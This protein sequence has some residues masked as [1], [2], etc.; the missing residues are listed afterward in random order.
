VQVSFVE[1]EELVKESRRA[2][3]VAQG[4]PH[5]VRQLMD[6]L[7]AALPARRAAAAAELQPLTHLDHR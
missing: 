7:A 5:V 4:Q 2:A 3:L 6:R 1:V